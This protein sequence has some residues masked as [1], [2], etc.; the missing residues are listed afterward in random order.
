MIG[1]PPL[2]DRIRAPR[3][4]HIGAIA[5]AVAE[6]ASEIVYR[7]IVSV[8]GDTG[9]V[10]CIPLAALLALTETVSVGRERRS[11]SFVIF[12][13]RNELAHGI[14]CSALHKASLK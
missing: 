1:L 13:L 8:V 5:H 12:L 2:A 9:L 3:D 6:A 14:R 11:L 7:H 10:S 4:L